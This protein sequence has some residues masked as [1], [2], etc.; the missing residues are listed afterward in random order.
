LSYN[1]L[2]NIATPQLKSH[3]DSAKLFLAIQAPAILVSTW[4]EG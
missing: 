4:F 3:V 1:H 2:T